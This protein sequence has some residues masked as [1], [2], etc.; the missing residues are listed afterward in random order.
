MVFGAGKQIYIAENSVEAE[1]VLILKISRIASRENGDMQGVFSLCDEIRYIKFS[2]VMRAFGHAGVFAVHIEK[3]GGAYALEAK[4][5]ALAG[6]FLYVK[7]A[8]IESDGIFQRDMRHIH[9]HGVIDIRILNLPVAVI[10]PAGGNGK[11]RIKIR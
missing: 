2:T 8:A 1:K 10:L 6:I 5:Y 11:L 7:N 9:L 3:E 4:I